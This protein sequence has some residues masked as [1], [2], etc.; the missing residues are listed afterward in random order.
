VHGTS[1]GRVGSA[2]PAPRPDGRG[3]PIRSRQFAIAARLAGVIFSISRQTD[4]E[5]RGADNRAA[6]FSA[7]RPVRM[8]SAAMVTD[9][10]YELQ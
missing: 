7:L 10:S 9:A 2:G 6:Q 3:R 5:I 4:C 8:F 1:T